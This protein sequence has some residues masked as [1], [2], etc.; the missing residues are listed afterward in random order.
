MASISVLYWQLYRLK[1]LLASWA[2]HYRLQWCRTCIPT[3]VASFVHS[4]NEDESQRKLNSYGQ[5]KSNGPWSSAHQHQV[6]EGLDPMV[7]IME[8]QRDVQEWL[9]RNTFGWMRTIISHMK[10]MSTQCQPCLRSCMKVCYSSILLHYYCLSMGKM[11]SKPHA[12]S[13]NNNKRIFIVPIK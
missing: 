10:R 7:G 5:L 2:K 6:V 9:L 11:N 12:K 13:N 1:I 3:E 8:C 4:S